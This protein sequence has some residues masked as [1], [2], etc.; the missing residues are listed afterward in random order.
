MFGSTI[1]QIYLGGIFLL[2]IY[3]EISQSSFH[4]QDAHQIQIR[5]RDEM[6]QQSPRGI[7]SAATGVSTKDLQRNWLWRPQTKKEFGAL[8]FE[9]G[10]PDI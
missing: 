1:P 7:Q 10:A 4:S 5:E 9:Q 6:A 8:L 3:K 2:I